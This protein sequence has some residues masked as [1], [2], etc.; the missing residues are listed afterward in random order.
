[1]TETR[2]AYIYKIY[3]DENLYIGSTIDIYERK[4]CHKVQS[5]PNNKCRHLSK[6]YKIIREKGG[7][8]KFK[9]EIIETFD[10]ID[11]QSKI[12]KEEYYIK[13]LNPNLNSIKAKQTKEE[14]KEQKHQNYLKSYEKN[15][16]K[17]IEKAKKWKNENKDR[18]N[19][20]ARLKYK[21]NKEIHI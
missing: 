6:L 14:R 16:E 19:E 9:F 2:K 7:Y 5:N 17:Y 12:T 10:Y 3:N 8:E 4:H 15:K 18:V 1:M 20:L 11:K 13:L 21:E